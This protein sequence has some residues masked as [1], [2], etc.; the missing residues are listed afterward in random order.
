MGQA[1]R[2]SKSTTR[3]D[4]VR[5][6][7]TVMGISVLSASVTTMLSA[8]VLV[9]TYIIFFL[10]FGTFILLTILMSTLWAFGF[11]MALLSIVGNTTRHDDWRWLWYK[12]RGQTPD[13]AEKEPEHYHSVTVAA[14]H[15]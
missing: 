7:L 15:V 5:D 3:F 13:D 14:A 10:K 2:E 12:L 1:Y 6:A 8:L 11:F 4:R 9:F